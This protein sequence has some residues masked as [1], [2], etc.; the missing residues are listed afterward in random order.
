MVQWQNVTFP[1]LR[2]GSDSRYPLMLKQSKYYKIR[3]TVPEESA[4]KVRQAIGK[5]GAGVQGNYSHCTIS[6]SGIG[7]FLPN[8]G[9][10]PA[11]GKIGRPEEVAEEI[12]EAICSEEKI[13]NVIAEIKRAHP[14]EEPAIDIMPR[15]DIV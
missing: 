15:F 10:K 14:Y 3:V 5:N 13:E 12:I 11:I 2:Y 9:A 6:Y 8:E 4:E 1:R 7:R